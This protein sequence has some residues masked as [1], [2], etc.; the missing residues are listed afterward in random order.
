MKR[1]FALILVALMLLPC[2]V[3]CGKEVDPPASS[4]V[5]STNNSGTTGSNGG[6]NYSTSTSNNSGNN[7]GD[8][9]NG[10]NGGSTPEAAPV[11]KKDW[12]GKTLRILATNWNNSADP[13]APWSQVEL[14]V[15]PEDFNKNT[16]F[17]TTINNAV[18][19]RQNFIKSEYG[20]D[21]EWVNARGTMIAT[22]ISDAIV[23]GSDDTRY[24]LAMPRMLEVQAI[25]ATNG[26]YDVSQ[27]EY[28]DLNKSYYNQAA[29][30]AYSVKG[31]TLFAAGDFS[32]LDEQ[33][34]NLVFYNEAM[35]GT[36]TFEQFPDLYKMVR[37]G[38]WTIDQM[39]NVAKL[40][41][42][43]EGTPEWTDEDTYGF[44]TTSLSKFYQYSGIQQVSVKDGKYVLSIND[45]GKIS[46]LIDKI[47]AIRAA[48]WAR[49][50]WD[51][52]YGAM[53]QAFKEGRLLFYN[54]VVQ[55]TDQFEAQTEEFKIGVL[56]TPKL[57]EA[58]ERYYTPCSY[59]SVVMCIPKATAN[60]EMSE[61]FFEILSYTGQKY[62]MEAYKDN[63][64]TKLNA[65]TAVE[66]MEIIENYIFANLCYD[67]GVMDGWNGL[68]T[69][70]QSE[71][72]SSGK[73]NFT[74][75]YELVEEDALKTVSKWN[76]NWELY[77]E[78]L[79]E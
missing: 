20:V 52:D 50:S 21:L 5:P 25:V 68:I 69:S 31:Y 51:G 22:I 54:E 49:T 73:N 32:F 76:T 56:P 6:T 58:Q 79:P 28:I 44:G 67:V 33:T 45:Q 41:K 2:I 27:S 62:I 29:R 15:K 1:F 36:D 7:G 38:K 23:G 43:N 12:A 61:Y 35:T 17:G 55:K 70:V 65:E 3:S 59:Q 57:N 74:A 34:A 64:R 53:E 26:I 19:A 63:L 78:E 16:G 66:S 42:K 8:N 47:L 40:V 14:T 46:T 72:Y 60:R 4:T 39:T 77:T 18:I 75:A 9:G 13:G 37:E 48:D 30:E 71:S 10:G 24:H 11:T